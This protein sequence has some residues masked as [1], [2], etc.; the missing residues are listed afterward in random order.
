MLFP[1]CV[2]GAAANEPAVGE[3][4]GDPAVEE[5]RIIDGAE[6]QLTD[7]VILYAEEIIERILLD[8]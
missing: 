3:L 4:L 5:G 6:G 2:P 1:F 8:E 7:E